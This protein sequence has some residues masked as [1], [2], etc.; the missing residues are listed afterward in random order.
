MSTLTHDLP[1]NFHFRYIQYT[2][3]ISVRYS[4]LSS[5]PTLLEL[6]LANWGQLRK[7]TVFWLASP[8]IRLLILA[9][10]FMRFFCYATSYTPLRVRDYRF[11]RTGLMGLTCL[12][13]HRAT[14]ISF[15]FSMLILSARVTAMSSFTSVRA[16]SQPCLLS[17]PA[18]TPD[19][20]FNLS[21]S[22]ST[23]VLSFQWPFTSCAL[24]PSPPTL[25][26]QAPPAAF[27]VEALRPS[28]TQLHVSPTCC[29]I[30]FLVAPIVDLAPALRRF[31]PDLSPSSNDWDMWRTQWL[32]FGNCC[33][34]SQRNYFRRVLQ[35]AHQYDFVRALKADGIDVS[36]AK[37]HRLVD[38]QRAIDEAVGGFRVQLRCVRH[39]SSQSPLLHRLQVCLSPNHFSV[40][41]CAPDQSTTT[42]DDSTSSLDT[43]CNTSASVSVPFR[44]H[45]FHDPYDDDSTANNS[46]EPKPP[47]T[48]DY[49]SLPLAHAALFVIA[50]L[51]T[52]S[53]LAFCVFYQCRF[54]VQHSRHLRSTRP[55]YHPVQPP[56]E[57][58]NTS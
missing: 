57:H 2:R 28:D 7:V 11:L 46:T 54:A 19:V 58:N 16:N 17:S 37:E 4:K 22:P 53:S 34:L 3:C 40:V 48:H 52:F 8:L 24:N 38:V 26:C 56:P 14:H 43:P 18:S 30:P 35:L 25:I 49:G 33:G 12:L 31:W 9:P 42:F 55:Y 21:F 41:D 5:L 27:T 36:G 1:Q 39:H 29:G 10:S 13:S 44:P 32:R 51:V 6:R 50:A 23:Y 47:K 20:S 45:D 15:L